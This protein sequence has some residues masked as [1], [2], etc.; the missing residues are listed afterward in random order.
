[1]NVSL[2]L[3]ISA[4][5][6][7]E[8]I[9]LA[10]LFIPSGYEI[11]ISCLASQRIETL[12][13]ILGLKIIYAY[14]RQFNLSKARNIGAR[15]ARNEW[16]L[17]SDIDTYFRPE[18]VEKVIETTT[19]AK[20]RYRCDIDSLKD[21][22]SAYSNVNN[23][24]TCIIDKSF[25]WVEAAPLVIQKK[26][27]ES[28]GGYCEEYSGCGMDSDFEHKIEQECHNFNC[29]ALH[30][31]SIHDLISNNQS[32]NHGQDNNR[33]LFDH[34]MT[35]PLKDRIESDIKT[36][37]GMFHEL[38]KYNKIIVTGPCRSG[39]TICAK[40]ISVDTGHALIMEKYFEGNDPFAKLKHIITTQDKIVVQCPV[41]SHRIHEFNAPDSLVVFMCRDINEIL[42]SQTRIDMGDDDQL[43]LLGL[44]RE[45][46]PIC[47][48]RYDLWDKQKQQLHNYLDVKYESLKNHWLWIDSGDMRFNWSPKQI[49]SWDQYHNDTHNLNY[50]MKSI[51]LC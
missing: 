43:T 16:L 20:G 23:M 49:D 9:E 46:G 21:V 5:I 38:T 28:I 7:P 2:I 44:K 6:Y 22:A 31:K 30:V 42:A 24:R 41:W 10:K 13:P 19:L 14:N 12:P 33:K 1:M 15:I 48:V 4:P 47:K 40:M 32:W 17:F 45:D 27:Y 37:K 39:T 26:L 51:F 36:Y 18:L 3:P 34:R 25:Y 50:G 11:I 35:I 8:T 29:E